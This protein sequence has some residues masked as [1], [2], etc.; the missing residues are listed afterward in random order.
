MIKDELEMEVSKERKSCITCQHGKLPLESPE[1]KACTLI[2]PVP[3][4]WIRKG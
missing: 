4:G 3:T 1:C 2:Y